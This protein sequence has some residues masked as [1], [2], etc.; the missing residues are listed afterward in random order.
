MEI[1]KLIKI[2]DKEVK[3]KLESDP[4]YR[5]EHGI[6]D[7]KIIE[8]SQPHISQL[9][10]LNEE[11]WSDPYT[12]SQLL[13]RQF[14]NEKKKLKAESDANDLIRDKHSLGIELLPELPSDVVRAKTAQ[15][16]STELLQKQKLKSTAV[17]PLFQS[18]KKKKE[19]NPLFEIAN[20]HTRLKTDPFYNPNPFST[21]PTTKPTNDTIVKP[22]II[23]KKQKTRHHDDNTSKSTLLVT[24]TDSESD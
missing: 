17:Q 19:K 24:Y 21:I 18:P 11:Q 20:I 14:R 7:K 8:A 2:L 9:Q 3:E 16:H 13:R 4:M 12:K 23:K 22:N 15:Y 1:V 6:K 10:H 5:L